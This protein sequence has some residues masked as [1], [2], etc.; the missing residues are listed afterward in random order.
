MQQSFV[1]TLKTGLQCIW[2][3]FAHADRGY[4]LLSTAQSFQALQSHLVKVPANRANI[5]RCC[6]DV[7]L[8]AQRQ[9]E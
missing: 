1:S 7:T 2:R 4:K 9:G 6:S 5:H 8:K 3:C